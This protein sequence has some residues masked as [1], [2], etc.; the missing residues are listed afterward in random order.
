MSTIHLGCS[1]GN[2]VPE[3]VKQIKNDTGLSKPYTSDFQMKVVKWYVKEVVSKVPM[4]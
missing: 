3:T 1:N 2:T 4:S